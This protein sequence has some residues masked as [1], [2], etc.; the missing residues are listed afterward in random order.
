MLK[1]TSTISK[2]TTL[3]DC[4]RT[5]LTF[6]TNSMEPPVNTRD[7]CTAKD[8]TMKDSLMNL[9]KRLCLNLFSQGEWKCLADP[10]ASCCMVNGCWLFLHLWIVISKLEIRLRLIRARPNFYMISDNPNVSFGIVDYSLY[11]R[12]SALKDHYHRKRM[13]ML[14]YTP[15]KFNSLEIFA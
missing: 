12:R 6:P 5:N 11:T 2:F 4:M 3:M 14:A 10:M 15:V 9:R 13:D 1:C 7:F 8:T